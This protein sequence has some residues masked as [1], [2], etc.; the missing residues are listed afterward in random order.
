MIFLL[1][2]I[3][4]TIIQ[5]A[6][7]GGIAY[8][9]VRLVSESKKPSSE[10]VGV[11]IRR[12]FVYS[13]ML[14]MLVLIGIGITGLIEAAMPDPDELTSSSS[15]TAM[16]IAFV[17]VALPVFM[18]LAL[19]TSRQLRQNPGEQ[20]S[21][22][23]VF[24][25][26]FALIESLLVSMSMI[27]AAAADVA[28]GRSVGRTAAIG[29]F[30]WTAIWVGHWWIAQRW[31]PKRNSQIHLVLGS[32]VGLSWM[33][34]GVIITLAAVLS[35]I[36]D[37]LF[38]TSVMDRGIARLVEPLSVLAVGLP[39]WWWYWIRHT[40]QSQRTRLWLI[41]VL[42]LGVLGGAVAMIS[43][44]GVTLYGLLVWIIGSS[45]SGASTHFIFLPG[46]AT[47]MIAGG[48][49]W[50]YHTSVLGNRE[51][52]GRTEVDRAYDYLLSG[53]GLVV[54]ATG[55]TTL[56]ATIL[57][58]VGSVQVI[59][60]TQG[61]VLAAAVTLI[62]IGAPLWWHYWSRIQRARGESPASELQSITRRV[63]IL[64]LLGVAA[65]VAVVSLIVIV[66]ILFE[67]LLN[68]ELGWVTVNDSAVAF[69]ILLA[70][71]ALTWYHFA[72]F[73]EDRADIAAG[74]DDE[75]A[76]PEEPTMHVV[77]HGSLELTLETLSLSGHDRVAVERHE[78][79]Y[80]LEPL[81]S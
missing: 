6:I 76:A 64:V 51:Q 44:A 50:V 43:G 81:D 46:A 27:G 21:F 23:W 47:A 30:V 67:D 65:V 33:S 78:D 26:T 7:I 14:A 34:T 39:V 29:A 22:G 17:L 2:G 18:G 52:R 38:L 13:I 63:Y 31:E 61:R 60:S 58:S 15:K 8:A 55:I 9:I 41:Y 72:V 24:Y 71:G 12:V 57:N 3:L 37:G 53:A 49:S 11:L 54:G 36:Y 16:S 59:S 69:A 62:A 20:K 80:V 68:S 5:L 19:Y 77:P 75:T 10:G 42:L 35:I 79:G 66:F 48:A 25:L 32:A 70:A 74:T 45:S 4:G 1:L 56:V 73:R 28:N 40:R